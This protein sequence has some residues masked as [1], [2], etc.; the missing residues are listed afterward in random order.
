MGCTCVRLYWLASELNSLRPVYTQ[1]NAQ[2]LELQ[3][4]DR[5]ME[6]MRLCLHTMLP[7][8]LGPVIGMAIKGHSVHACH[9]ATTESVA[10]D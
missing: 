10:Y 3:K 4:S 1:S 6:Q 9:V 2:A 5:T 8:V 7:F